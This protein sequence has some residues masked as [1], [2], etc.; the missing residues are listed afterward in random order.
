[1][2]EFRDVVEDNHKILEKYVEEEKENLLSRKNND[3]DIS[4]NLSKIIE[5][6]ADYDVTFH[7]GE[8]LFK[9]L[10]NLIIQNL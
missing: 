8:S 1:M 2:F 3:D 7:M 4:M 9:I 10:N 6:I 5:K